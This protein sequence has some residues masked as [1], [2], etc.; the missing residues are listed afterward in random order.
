MRPKEN[1]RPKE[2]SREKKETRKMTTGKK[3]SG[4]TERSNAKMKQREEIYPGREGIPEDHIEEQSGDEDGE[5]NRG[6]HH[7]DGSGREETRKYKIKE[8]I[9]EK[10]KK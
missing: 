3:T 2:N 4:K 9:Y 8:T 7:A 10:K 5:E 1:A 6:R